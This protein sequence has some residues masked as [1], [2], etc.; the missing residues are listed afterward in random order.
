[1]KFIIKKIYQYYNLNHPLK[2]KK[3]FFETGILHIFLILDLILISYLI[4]RK[5]SKFNLN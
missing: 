2:N 4:K 1:M 5:I 3:I